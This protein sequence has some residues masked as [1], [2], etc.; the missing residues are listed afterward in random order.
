[1]PI[2][3]AILQNKRF[4]SMQAVGAYTNSGYLT[5]RIYVV[6]IQRVYMLPSIQFLMRGINPQWCQS[7][8]Y[9]HHGERLSKPAGL[10][11]GVGFRGI[12]VLPYDVQCLRK[13]IP[14]TIWV[15]HLKKKSM[16]FS[17]LHYNNIIK[18]IA[19]KSCYVVCVE[20]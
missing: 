18:K 14:K 19:G 12:P 15:Y 13:N 11:V 2:T 8:E 4:V 7:M 5:S 20:G 10:L 1:M 3:D 17:S 9:H 16:T 6:M